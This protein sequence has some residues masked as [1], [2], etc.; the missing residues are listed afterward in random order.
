MR[1]RSCIVAL[2]LAAVSAPGFASIPSSF[3]ITPG[4]GAVVESISTIEIFGKSVSDIYSYS[5]P[6]I[7]INGEAVTVT[8]ET[9][10]TSKDLLTYTLSE[11][12][13]AP[14]EYEIIIGEASFYYD[15][16]ETDNSEISWK[17]SIEDKA[18][19]VPD[20]PK[21][22]ENPASITMSPAQGKVSALEVFTINFTDISMVDFSSMI[23]VTLQDYATGEVVA[24]ATVKDGPNMSDMLIT[25]D[26][27]VN[28]PGVYVLDVPEGV[29]CDLLTDEDCPATKWLYIVEG[30]DI[31][32]ETPDNITSTPANG[33][34]LESVDAVTVT[35]VD[36]EVVYIRD[37]PEVTVVNSEG[38]V[39]ATAVLEHATASNAVVAKFETPIAEQGKYTFTIPKN[40]VI[41][42][43]DGDGAQYNAT[44]TV[45]F[46]VQP[47]V[48]PD[49]Y[50][51][52][53]ITIY[54]AQGR[55][56][57]L[58]EFTLTFTKIQLPDINYKKQITV[59]NNA[60]Q[61]VVATGTASTGAIIQQI[62]IDLDKPVLE[63]GEYT[64][65]CPEGAFYNAGSWDE[66]DMPEYKFLY[67]L[68][69]TGEI[70]PPT[71]D[72][73]A[74]YPMSGT[75]VGALE[76]VLLTY[77]DYSVVYRHDQSGIKVLDDNGTAV[78]SGSFVYSSDTEANQMIVEFKPTVV[79]D[80]HYTVVI[81]KRA[82]IFGDMKDGVFSAPLEL[83]Y[84]VE[85][86]GVDN[87]A[88]DG[89]D[90]VPDGVYN[91]QGVRVADRPES[92]PAGLYIYGGK[93]IL[94]K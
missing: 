59:V 9:S 22:F 21:P 61:E 7:R 17:V 14:G 49:I 25:L 62:V 33:E 52:D 87:V 84:T 73:V 3:T 81:P 79:T 8:N 70:V 32:E 2:A 31:P 76:Q 67:V 72:N 94:V 26:H 23:A 89:A 60:T 77:Y 16:Y 68:D 41:L 55:Y 18:D 12:I 24:N 38:T 57:S 53:D 37:Q 10:G 91:L 20:E 82:L 83:E 29:F 42:G 93:K 85:S 69:G 30:G 5:E 63:A 65:I 46:G 51:Y 28:T 6:D 88:A 1:I 45:K 54:P 13:T 66:E 4:D 64:L 43:E 36:Y 92:L 44:V 35:F 34:V 27:V 48:M 50:E 39:V 80:G 71:P 90:A 78:A 86:A 56:G 47:F 15:W 11:P 74:A 19:P 75:T 40:V 58:T